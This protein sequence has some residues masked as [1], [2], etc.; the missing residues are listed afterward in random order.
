VTSDTANVT[1]LDDE[2]S[3]TVTDIDLTIRMLLRTF[4]DSAF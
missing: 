1:G 3:F 4:T 2:N